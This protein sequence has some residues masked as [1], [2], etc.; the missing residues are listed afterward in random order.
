MEKISL[1][2]RGSERGF[3][4]IE[5]IFVIALLGG[6]MAILLR[7]I[8][9]PAEKARADEARLAM[10][11]PITQ[12]LQMY[13]IHNHKFP[14]SDQGLKA[15]LS[16]P[17]DVKGWAGPYVTE[18]QLVDPWSNEYS[19]ESDGRNYKI[20]SGGPDGVLDS[21]DDISFPEESGKG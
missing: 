8:Q 16:D 9:G 4:L 13:Q 12:G 14:T 20:R 3:T 6:L 21:A 11:G 7:A 2:G 5:I 15:L 10:G 1:P 19:Y 17:G 18:G